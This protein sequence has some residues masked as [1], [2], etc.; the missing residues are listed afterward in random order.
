MLPGAFPV[1]AAESELMPARPQIEEE[2][3]NEVPEISDA[4]NLEISSQQ[5]PGPEE[6]EAAG[7]DEVLTAVAVN[8]I[9]RDEGIIVLLSA[10][11]NISDALVPL[12][13]M[14]ELM[15]F[16]INVNAGD[17]K[18]E[19][20]FLKEENT[21]QLDLNTNDVL[22][23]GQKR[24]LENGEARIYDEDIYVRASSLEEWFNVDIDLDTGELI[25]SIRTGEDLPFQERMK[26]M[27][28]YEKRKKTYR[29]DP[30]RPE[31]AQLAPYRNFSF[32]S[33]YLTGSLG[34]QKSASDTRAIGAGTIQGYQ[35]IAKFEADY[36]V[37]TRY[38]SQTANEIT[39]A[40][41]TF[42]KRDASKQLLG[43]LK[44]GRISFGDVSFPSVPLFQG[45]QRGAGFEVSSDSRLGARYANSTENFILDGDAPVGYDAELY[46]NGAFVAFQQ[47]GSD[48]RY[49][50]EN[51]NLSNGFNNF[52]VVLY[53][54]QGQKTVIRR[55]VTRGPR[56][57]RKNELQYDFALGTPEADF[58]PLADRARDDRAFGMS[59]QAFYGFTDF[60][61]MGASVY[62]GPQ[63]EVGSR[64]TNFGS[65]SLGLSTSNSLNSSDD[66][67]NSARAS[68]GAVSVSTAFKGVILQGQALAADK[69]RSAYELAATSRPF[70]VNL[71]VSHTTYK[72]FMDNEQEIGS[73]SEISASRNF[74]AFNMT[75]RVQDRDFLV[76][77]DDRIF[78]HIVSFRFMGINLNNDLVRTFSDNDG[79]DDFEGEL[80]ALTNLYNTRL[81]ASLFYDL[82]PEAERT[83]RRISFSG[84][85]SLT[86]R[87]S[88]RFEGAHDFAS[89]ID[90]IGVRYSRDY[91]KFGLDFDTTLNTEDDLTFLVGMRVALQPDQKDDYHFVD[92]RSG[93]Q[94]AIGMRSFVDNNDNGIFDND[95]KPIE[96]VKF[97][98]STRSDKSETN[99]DG[100]SYLTNLGEAP[101]RIAVQTDS[102]PDIYL[103]PK[104]EHRDLIPRRGSTPVVDFPFVRMSEIAGYLTHLKQGVEGAIVRLI[105]AVDGKEIEK[106]ETDIDGYYIFPAVKGGNYKVSFGLPERDFMSVNVVLDPKIEIPEEMQVEAGEEL[107]KAVKEAAEIKPSANNTSSAAQKNIDRMNAPA[108]DLPNID[109][110]LDED[111]LKPLQEK[112][113]ESIITQ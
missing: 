45:G 72:N 15:T 14:S 20:F 52:E 5:T 62:S 94:A 1:Q 30:V 92:P 87:S 61:T 96:G 81:R 53:G 79:I 95:D 109:D 41:L 112:D 18:A 27:M 78:E 105:S 23:M 48:G 108:G 4:E 70:G 83:Y 22:V 40:R 84:Q 65:T 74:G 17:K 110:P 10:G 35:D 90:S 91:D 33:L 97:G 60:L 111:D 24:Q 8:G 46:R 89:E 54:P 107:A 37:G 34:M 2:D 57:L 73:I 98:A 25:L 69:G 26:R 63:E 31:N 3:S 21:F 85:R 103:A 32:P 66:F 51:L 43:P 13:K 82:D 93:G 76:R 75:L 29:F 44:A 68:G 11:A 86:P 88:I 59:G 106:T 71:G 50:F 49:F 28:R 64:Y 39:N 99:A 55:D 77:A 113:I 12:G 16:A 58:I 102:I 56:S 9:P 101:V 36:T 80:T 7:E 19:G 38:S 6:I 100:V 42:Q 47:I 104:F 67:E